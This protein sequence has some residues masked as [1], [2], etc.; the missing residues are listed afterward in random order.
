MNSLSWK[1]A[2]A[3]GAPVLG[4]KGPA[5][6][7]Q[8]YFLNFG[9]DV[10]LL[11]PAGLAA[12]VAIARLWDAVSDPAVG[13]LSDHTRSRFGRRRPWMLMSGPLAAL[14]FFA[15]WTPPHALTGV[16]LALWCGAALLAFTTASTAW[17]IP[18]Q[19]LG[20]ELSPLPEVRTRLFG[21]RYVCGVLGA[22]A[23]FGAMQLIV[24]AS[25]PRAMAG[26]LALWVG[27]A[28]VLILA[29]PALALREPPVAV[30][31]TRER[32]LRALR[33]VLA[34]PDGRRLYFIWFVD[35]L[36]MSSQGAIAPYMT[37]YV[38]E[39]PDL[40]GMM[41]V[42]FIGPMI[43]AVPFW[44][45]L[46][47]RW[48]AKRAW[49]VS[50]WGASAS[51]ASLFLLDSDRVWLAP[52][53]LAASGFCTGCGGPLGPTLLASVIDRDARETGQRREG[54]FFATWAFVDKA[55]GAAIILVIGFA[56]QLSGFVP[57]EPLSPASD[58]AI[59]ACL[60]L[61][62][63]AMF[64]LAALALRGLPEPSEPAK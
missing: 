47:R 45:R 63:S 26:E 40:I 51:Y 41:P 43:L 60:A 23:S 49:F 18:H 4:I 2:T 16:T 55:S 33:A 10:L 20:V 12:L 30:S 5:F 11:A 37:I 1:K 53:V 15:V 13:Y 62:P 14:A 57:N 34:N 35:Q 59:R 58:F 36:A 54:L 27:L 52:I 19:A 42:F 29:I 22:A 61:L 32:P 8:S 31:P 6:L 24:N 25:D 64:A 50:M 7:V 3:Y 28:M 56:L 39:R 9:T 38:I 44:V 46:A 17:A 48:G 21:L